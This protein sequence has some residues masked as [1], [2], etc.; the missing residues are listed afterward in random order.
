VKTR[1]G[2]EPRLVRLLGLVSLAMFFES[3][4]LSMLTSALKHIADDLGMAEHDLGGYLGTIRLGALPAI[5]VV[6]LADR[7][8]RRAVFLASLIGMSV[9]T[10]ATALAHD[11]HTFVAL[12]MFM[13]V[14]V[15]AATAVAIVI[16]TEEFPAANRGWAIGVMGAIASSGHGLGA[17]LFSQ[18]DRLPYGWRTLY[19]L[20]AL[21]LLLLPQFWRGVPET[22]RFVRERERIRATHS[23]NWLA[24]LLAL[25]RTYPGRAAGLT[26]AIFLVSLGDVS[27]F[28]FTSYYAQKVHGWSPGE[29]AAMF[30]GA[31]AVGVVGNVVAGR[32]GDVVGRRGVGLAAFVLFPLAAWL[33]YVGPAWT[34]PI[35][36]ASFVF[37][38]TAG[39]TILR[40]LSSELFPTSH[41]GTAAAWAMLVQTIGWA[42]GLWVVGLGTRSGAAIAEMTTWL[43]MG[44]LLGGLLL[45]TLPETKRRELETISHDDGEAT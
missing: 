22:T 33:F 25:G 3:Y 43:S 2:L 14:F 18:I 34:M 1:F 37:C 15:V 16:V 13:R 31:G 27:V 24:P 4:D 23:G 44:V 36:F 5:V 6:P 12:Q 11:P 42:A 21:P 38:Q 29:Y 28:Q 20:G 26:A 10:A 7:L 8:G 30:V 9:T 19:V 32:L 45:L 35:A 41:R 39:V 17:L 40:A